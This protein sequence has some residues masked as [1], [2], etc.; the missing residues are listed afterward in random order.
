MF[1]ICPKCALKN[2][3][4]SVGCRKCLTDLSLIAPISRKSLVLAVKERESNAWFMW[5]LK[6]A[7]ICLL[8]AAAVLCGF[9]SSLLMTSE[10]L[11]AVSK[12]RIYRAI[13]VLEVKGFSKEARMLRHTASFRA[14]DNWLNAS[15]RDENAF[16]ATNFP[17]QIVTIYPIFFENSTD[18]TE[19]AA[20]LLHE[21]RHLFGDG[22][23]EAYAFFWRNRQ[24][25]GWTADKYAH[26]KVWHSVEKVTREE[27][28]ELFVCSWNADGDCTK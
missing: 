6:R 21:A 8:V 12:Q 15:T 16:A 14:N 17:F 26:S 28:P 27:V 23:H 1:K 4:A 25:L 24:K 3:A 22:E 11:D 10:P 9:Y 18:A 7:A 19:D 20:I 5:I 2:F 13:D